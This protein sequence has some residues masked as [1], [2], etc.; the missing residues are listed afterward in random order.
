MSNLV[1]WSA[2]VAFIIPLLMAL[3]KQTQWPAHVKAA[4]F[5]GVSLIAAGGTAYFQGELTGK[6]WLDSAL[7]IVPAAAAFYHGFWKPVG[8][9]PKLEEVTTISSG[10]TP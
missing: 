10:S 7:I 5:F 8:I 9:A 3:L 1:Q 6:R 2:I 4:L